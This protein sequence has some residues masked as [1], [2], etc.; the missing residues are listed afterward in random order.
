MSDLK[1]NNSFSVA[2]LFAGIGGFCKAFKK[3]GFKIKWANEVDQF[4]T[5]TYEHNFPKVKVYRK[6]IDDLTVVADK[7]EPVDVLTAGFPCQPF[8]VAGNKAGFKDPRGKL[9]FEI[10][11]LLKEFGPNRPKIVILENVKNIRNHDSCK[12]FSSIMNEMQSAGYWF[13]QSNATVL[14]TKIH[15]T[16]PQNRERLFMVALSWDA[17]D[18]N[19]FK[20]P[21]PIDDTEFYRELLDLDSPADPDYYFDVKTKYGKLFAAAMKKG[22]PESVYQLRRWYVRELKDFLVPTLTA[23][24]GEGGHNK[25]VIMDNWGIR[26][27][28]PEECLRLQGFNDGFSFPET[29]SFTQRYKQVGNTVTV[30]IVENIALECMRR[31]RSFQGGKN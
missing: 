14:D 22:N 6:S 17:F 27:L 7:L 31:L 9:F 20:F 5:Q 4:A 2:S 1:C 30:P 15:S 12:T 26:N 19:D 10:V 21:D 3:V 23:N 11:R 8:S 18:F 29:L 25:P 16:I 13:K 28:T 24:M